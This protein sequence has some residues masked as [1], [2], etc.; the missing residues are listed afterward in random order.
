M[1]NLKCENLLDFDQG[2]DNL[3]FEKNRFICYALQFSVWSRNGQVLFHSFKILMLPKVGKMGETCEMLNILR[4]KN[5][6]N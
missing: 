2:S 1:K 4:Y 3:K 6:S 5:V